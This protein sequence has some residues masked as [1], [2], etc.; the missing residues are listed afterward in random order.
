MKNERCISRETLE[1][2]DRE[3]RNPEVDTVV[4]KT[5]YNGEFVIAI[6]EETRVANI[7]YKKRDSQMMPQG[8]GKIISSGNKINLP[9]S[10]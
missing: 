7:W 1:L 4:A 8:S 10:P 2:I 3:L 9:L 6:N 5:T